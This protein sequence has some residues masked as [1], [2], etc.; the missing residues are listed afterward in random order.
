M[1]HLLLLLILATQ[2]ALAET[3]WDV[4]VIGF[5][6]N[7]VKQMGVT[8]DGPAPLGPVEGAGWLDWTASFDRPQL[9]DAVIAFLEVQGEC[10][11]L[12]R[13][14]STQPEL[15]YDGRWLQGW[16]AV[17]PVIRARVT[18]GEDQFVLVDFEVS[19]WF[20]EEHE[21]VQGLFRSSYRLKSG[22]FMGFQCLERGYQPVTA[23]GFRCTRL[24]V[25][26]SSR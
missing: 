22:E 6:E 13:Y 25:R 10:K 21:L 23:D 1:R 11:V 8:W 24:Y 14:T 7:G 18:R 3:R 15:D 5:T 4:Y 12:A 19:S 26:A 20:L 2:A 17:G 16:S 9:F